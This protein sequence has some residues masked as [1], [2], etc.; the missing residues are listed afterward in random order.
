MKKHI[1]I[2]VL[3]FTFGLGYSQVSTPQPVKVTNTP[4]FVIGSG[5][6][7][8]S[9]STTGIS[10]DN[11][12][13]YEASS[14][15]KASAGVLLGFTGYNSKTSGQWIQIHNTASLP[16]DAQVPIIIIYVPAQSSFSY[17]AGEGGM[18]MSTGIT[19]CNSSTGP[20]KT[21]GSADCWVNLKYK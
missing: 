2:L 6:V 9:T 17:D 13:A 16:A 20:T 14:V 15:S 7:S 5:N 1:L 19:W 12:A 10:W 21:I 11:S 3:A 18:V 8:T 4:T